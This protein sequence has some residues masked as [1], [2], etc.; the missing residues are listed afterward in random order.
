MAIVILIIALL[1]LLTAG[2]VL[3]VRY[4]QVAARKGMYQQN[5]TT[6][7]REVDA[8]KALIDDIASVVLGLAPPHVLAKAEQQV[9]D[10]EEAVRAEQGRLTITQAEL[11]A[12]ETRLRELEEVE[13]ELEA[14]SIESA[15]EIEMLRSQQRDIESRNEALRQQL[16]SA[17][18]QIE[19]LLS[20]FHSSQAA[21]DELGAL[22]L[23]LEET[24][25]KIDYYTEQLAMLNER[26]TELK[27]AYDALDIEYAQLYEKHN[28]A[29]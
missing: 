12:V 19:I 26:Y 10:L 18:D 8:K 17:F 1:F 27:N 14:S 11:D 23:G 29:S 3:G 16:Q 25:A 6:I 7:K 13:R 20:Q 28:A 22:K 24:Q 4:S 21:V 5:L 15:K 9:T 2:G